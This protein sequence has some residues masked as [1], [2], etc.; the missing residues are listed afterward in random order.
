MTFVP[1]ASK[2]SASGYKQ[3]ANMWRPQV[4]PELY[5]LEPLAV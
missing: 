4:I 2:N 1:I 5:D 3:A